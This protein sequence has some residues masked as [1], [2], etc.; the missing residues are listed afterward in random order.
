[1]K[2]KDLE[3]RLKTAV[4]HSVPNVLPSI[5]AT[6]QEQKGETIKMENIKRKKRWPAFVAAAAALILVAVGVFAGVKLTSAKA[7][8]AV[9]QLDVNPSIELSVN[10]NE[11]ILDVITRNDAATDVIGDMD[12]KD[13]D[14][15]VAVN[16][17][18]GSMLTK[19]Y[20]N[21][22]ANSVLLSVQGSEKL[23]AATL[24]Q[25]LTTAID[26]ALQASS[27]NGGAIVSQTLT[28][29]SD[30]EALA[31]KYGISVGK[32]AFITGVIEQN[33]HLTFELL[34]NLSINELNL[35]CSAQ[36]LTPES[37]DISGSASDAAYIGTDAA[38]N[39]AYEHAGI[40]AAEAERVKIKLDYD[41]GLMVYEIEFY[42]AS[43]EHD[44]EINAL[45]GEVVKFE[46]EAGSVK[47]AQG[48]DTTTY[49]TEAEAKA[50]ALN[51]AGISEADTLYLTIKRGND[52]GVMEY[53]IEFYC[54]GVEYDYEINAITGDI[55]SAEKET[56][57]K[58]QATA[59]PTSSPA[60]STQ[61]ITEAQAKAIALNHAG[62]SE[63]DTTYIR[64]KMERDDGVME[65]QVDF[66]ANGYEYEYE[67]NAT[68]G[69]I[70]S[71]EKDRDD[72]Y[73]DDD[74]DDDWDDDDDDDDD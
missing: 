63:S 14:V 33:P 4:E 10:S 73:D 30:L 59:S 40:T 74:W 7:V 39:A 60:Q 6:I 71:S 8:A 20:L 58:A 52:D 15:D 51:H 45:T 37:V 46:S 13:T 57:R 19:G 35:L 44:Y 28:Q 12:L 2:N 72:D 9:V 31:E 22:A 26:Q 34:V 29:N 65:Y 17:I 54:N 36:Q 38:L 24:R 1:M 50:I 43:I 27:L 68:T 11:R 56:E 66:Y 21:E 23:D 32:A 49:I 64:V 67:I 41:D 42:V 18:I 53:E 69:K 62:V 5:L 3:L 55:I 25:R 61:Y 48:T 70:L 47:P 16:A